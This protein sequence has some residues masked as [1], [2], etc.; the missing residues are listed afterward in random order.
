MK[1]IFT[2]F[3]A[4][5]VISGINGQV[6]YSEDFNGVTIGETG[7]GV[8]PEGFL[9]INYDGKTPASN[10]SYMGNNAWILTG[11]TGAGSVRSISWYD[12]AGVSDDWLIL[13]EISIPAT[14]GKVFFTFDE[15]TID[16]SYPDGYQV[17]VSTTGTEK[18]DFTLVSSKASATTEWSRSA[19]D[20]SAYVGNTVRI[21][22]VN[23]SNDKFI[24]IMDNFKVEEL[25]DNNATLA[26]INY[27]KY[28][29][30][31]SSQNIGSTLYNSGANAIESFTY[32]WTDG[33]DTYTKFV[34]NVN[35]PTF[36]SYEI[37]SDDQLDLPTTGV[38]SFGVS[39]VNPNGSADSDE[40]DNDGSG[41]F[42]VVSGD[43]TKKV[44]IEEGT[45]TWCGWC[46]RGAVAMEFMREN[47]PETFVGIAVHNGDPMTVSEYDDGADISAFPGANVGRSSLG[48]SVGTSEFES[49]YATERE[50]PTPA[51][52]STKAIYDRD[53]DELTI[54]LT[55]ESE[56]DI[57]GDYRF[58][59]VLVEDNVSG[60]DDG[61]AQVNYYS[62][63]SQNIA[64]SGAGHNWQQE[65][66]TVP[67]T[68]MEYDDVGRVLLGGYYGVADNSGSLL[69]G[70]QTHTF[71]MKLEG[72]Y[73]YENIWVAGLLLDNDFGGQV[74][75]VD[76]D[77]N[78]EIISGTTELDPNVTR[79]EIF[80]NPAGQYTNLSL[81]LNEAGIVNLSIY[82]MNGK[83]VKSEEVFFNEGINEYKLDL[84]N[85][86]SGAYMLG[87][88]R[89]GK[90]YFGK[91]NVVK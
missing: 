9:Q 53:N 61:Y 38:Y 58:A 86:N 40:T 17:W 85:I 69:E 34:D 48:V 11:V 39:V 77:R 73:S 13:P 76:A 30:S 2:L 79:F 18:A 59:A 81:N 75:N 43:Y 44:L 54:T 8:L 45:G 15:V 31:G 74:V 57:P 14:S 22:V 71:T 82:D 65:P 70:S 35:I 52:V 56:F 89:N 62:S 19:V 10:L 64:L 5:L 42:V 12:P 68:D 66:S 41:S 72:N 83:V 63:Q 88:T 28:Q 32:T 55:V 47:Y 21:A 29:K 80:P 46:P 49:Y 6:Y 78:V 27:G 4:L 16:P 33:V 60:T 20:I 25:R 90:T 23:N 67:A 36:G 26:S 91:L 3:I 37:T 24:L 84:S 51:E 7:I 87:T 50:A 1:K